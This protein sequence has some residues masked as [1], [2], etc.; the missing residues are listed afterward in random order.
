MGRSNISKSTMWVYKG[1]NGLVLANCTF[2][3]PCGPTDL[4]DAGASQLNNLLPNTVMYFNG[5]NYNALNVPGGTSPVT[6]QMG[7]SIHSRTAD[8]SHP[9]SG[10]ERSIFNGAFILPGNNTLDS[11]TLLSTTDTADDTGVLINGGNNNVINN[12]QIGNTRNTFTLGIVDNGQNT[13]I[14]NS[15]IFSSKYALNMN[16]TSS[17]VLNSRVTAKGRNATGIYFY[18]NK[19]SNFVKNTQIQVIDGSGVP[20]GI[21]A[22]GSSVEVQDSIIQASGSRVRGIVSSYSSTISIKNT[23]I[24]RR[25]TS[26]R[27]EINYV[28]L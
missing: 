12:S 2:E 21:Y 11:I 1:G 5:G 20:S 25:V 13:I 18:K 8:Y 14:N 26:T 19:T 7:Q 3:N 23:Q 15:D 6:L 27:G 17:S 24:H 22:D 4:T 10:T 16:G 9:V 28:T